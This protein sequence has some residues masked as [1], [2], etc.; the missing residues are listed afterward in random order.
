MY[1]LLPPRIV[2]NVNTYFDI[3]IYIEREILYKYSQLQMSTS[4]PAYSCPEITSGAAPPKKKY[5]VSP[6]RAPKCIT[7]K[8]TKT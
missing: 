1:T 3:Y 7:F 4:A 6:K 2:Y 8:E 5:G